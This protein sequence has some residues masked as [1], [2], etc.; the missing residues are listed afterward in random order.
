[1]TARHR[2]VGV[3]QAAGFGWLSAAAWQFTTAAGMAAVGV[4]CLLVAWLWETPEG[5]G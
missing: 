2:R 1:M 5:T 3:L 4:S